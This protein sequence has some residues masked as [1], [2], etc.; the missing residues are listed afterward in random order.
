MFC[1]A[2]PRRTCCRKIT[3][4]SFSSSS[5]TTPHIQCQHPPSLQHI[6][7][8]ALSIRHQHHIFHVNTHCHFNTSTSAPSTSDINTTYSMSTSTVALLHQHQFPQNPTSTPYILCQH[9]LPLQHN[10]SALSIRHQHHI[11]R[12]NIHCCFITSTPVPTASDIN[13]TY[14]MSVSIITSTS[15]PT[16][17]DIN[18]VELRYCVGDHHLNTKL[19]LQCTTFQN[20]NVLIPNPF[21][22]QPVWP[23]GK[24]LGWQA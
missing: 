3:A 2:R 22:F 5:C 7:I 23:S 18:T 1:T 16:A 11:F 17:S 12:V 8:S 20:K 4:S 9:P 24:V 14:S 10:I 6:N 21:V 13:T 19:N 15:A